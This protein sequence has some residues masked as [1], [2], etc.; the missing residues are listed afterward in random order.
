M[1]RTHMRLVALIAT[2][3]LASGALIADATT[4]AADPVPRFLT[5]PFKVTR[6]MRIQ[7]GDIW[8]GPPQPG[9]WHGGIDY[10]NG[11]LD[12]SRTWK[13]F[14]VYAAASGYACANLTDRKG[15]IVGN[16]NRVLITHTIKGRTY[17]SYYG[18][19]EAISTRI[20]LGGRKTVFVK[21]GELIGYA[22]YSGDPCCV[23]HLHFQL[24]DPKWRT[25]D[26]YGISGTR[27]RYPDPQGT[28]GIRNGRR[29]YWRDDPPRA[30]AS[31]IDRPVKRIP[32]PDKDPDP[33]RTRTPK[34]S[35]TQ[36]PKPRPTR[37]PRPT[38]RPERTPRPTARPERTP[39]PTPTARP[40]ATPAADP[41]V[42]PG[43]SLVAATRRTLAWWAEVV[44]RTL[45]A[46]GIS[47]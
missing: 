43:P 34:P 5:L 37:T 20:P 21:R 31:F 13:T 18:H 23:R 2:L 41:V 4:L 7:Q 42:R 44:L 30:P 35:R 10:I 39:R 6:N 32:Y 36:R 8:Q 38:R 19:L 16:G 17:R 1:P 33:Q 3:V 28:N 22:G 14:P 15:C 12:R 29:S 11:R 25:V 9:H 26:P 27:G 40:T 47:A 24:F 46:F 45:R